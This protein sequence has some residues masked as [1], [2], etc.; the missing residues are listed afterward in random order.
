MTTEV[1]PQTAE[2]MAIRSS[3][4]TRRRI[5][6]IFAR[7]DSTLWLAARAITKFRETG[8]VEILHAWFRQEL[9]GDTG[10][11]EKRKEQDSVYHNTVLP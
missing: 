3:R 5:Q 6:E 1:C 2:V 4:E 8:R 10:R 9:P 11:L 7:S